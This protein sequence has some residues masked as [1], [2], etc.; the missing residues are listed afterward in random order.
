MSKTATEKE[1]YNVE[2]SRDPITRVAVIEAWHKDGKRHREDGPAAIVR[3]AATGIVVK[4]LWVRN[5]IYH[6]EDGPAVVMRKAATGA[7]YFSEWYNNGNK[8]TPPRPP[9]RQA[10]G[11]TVPTPKA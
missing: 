5:N 3:D 4:E 8:I 10:K 11:S 2:I 7:I 1:V 6:R 9:R